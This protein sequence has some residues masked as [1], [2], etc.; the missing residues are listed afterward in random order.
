M[1]E[2]DFEGLM[3][4]FAEMKKAFS[5]ENE[6]IKTFQREEKWKCDIE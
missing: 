4:W 6:W 5:N 2:M 3:E 1:Y